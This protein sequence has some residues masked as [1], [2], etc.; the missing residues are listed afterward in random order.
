MNKRILTILTYITY[1]GNLQYLQMFK[2]EEI[3]SLIV[4]AIT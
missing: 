1:S 4:P 2:A 3:R